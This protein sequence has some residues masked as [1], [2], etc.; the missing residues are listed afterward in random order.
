[1]PDEKE[2]F[3]IASSISDAAARQ[4]YLQQVCGDDLS[5]LNDVQSLLQAFETDESLLSGNAPIE[6]IEDDFKG[7]SASIVIQGRYKLLEQ[8]GEGGFGEVFM[9]EQLEPVRRRV[10]LKIIKAGM[11]SKQVLARFDAEQQALAMM[12]HPFVAKVIDAGQTDSGRPFF[13]MELVHGIPIID[14]CDEQQLTTHERLQLFA[15]V[16]TAVQHAHQKGIIHRDLKPTNILVYSDGDRSIP[17]IIDFGIA[18]ALHGRLTEKTLFTNFRQF[19]GT[20][21]YM[22]PEQARM[23]GVNV[24]TRSDIYSLGILLYELLTGTTPF[25]KEDLVDAGMDEVCRRI[26]DVPIPSPTQKLSSFQQDRMTQLARQRRTDPKLLRTAVSGE[27]DWI[28]MKA[29]EKEQRRRY[30]TVSALRSDVRNFLD[31]GHV[32]AVPPSWIY[33]ARCFTRR[34]RPLVVATTLVFAALVLGTAVST[35]FAL[36]ATKAEKLAL[37][38]EAQALS[39]AYDADMLLAWDYFDKKYFPS[40][41]KL[42]SRWV[43]ENAA[44]DFRGWEWRLL[45]ARFQDDAV[46]S[47]GDGQDPI[48]SMDDSPNGEWL[49][50]SGRDGALRVWDLET[51]RQVKHL[52]EDPNRTAHYNH[53]FFSP[54]GHD[55]IA[56]RPTGEIRF[57]STDTW[58]PLPRRKLEHGDRLRSMALSD[59][60]KWI[61]A[62]GYN[63]RL[64]VWDLETEKRYEK[65]L[66]GGGDTMAGAVAISQDSNLLAVACDTGLLRIVSLRNLEEIKELHVPENAISL[67]FAPDGTELACGLAF[68]NRNVHIFDTSTWELSQVLRGHQG[69]MRRVRFSSDGSQLASASADGTVRVWHKS[70]SW[71]EDRTYRGHFSEVWSVMFL[72]DNRLASGGKD[73]I[74]RVFEG[75]PQSAVPIELPQ[76]FDDA[77]LSPNGKTVVGIRDGTVELIT[78]TNF[79]TSQALDGLGEH[80]K[81]TLFAATNNR[82]AVSGKHE[83]SIIDLSNDGQPTVVGTGSIPAPV[84]P[85]QFSKNGD[86]LLTISDKGRIELWNKEVELLDNRVK[87]RHTAVIPLPG[88]NMAIVYDAAT[89]SSEVVDFSTGKLLVLSEEELSRLEAKHGRLFGK[90]FRRFV[91]TLL[92]LRSPEEV[93]ASRHIAISPDGN[94]IAR[95]YSK[96]LPITI[97]DAE[98]EREV[99]RL[100]GITGFNFREISFSGDGNSLLTSGFGN[101]YI[102][103]APAIHE[104]PN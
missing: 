50:T 43:P 1:M 98:T 35:W 75:E 54:S 103:R 83:L 49:A 67:D 11:D 34:H 82:F 10:A 9:A 44:R 46:A 104:L 5:L 18:K 93:F 72:G 92:P 59:D 52:A 29:L 81:H 102:W 89:R 28:V 96:S 2:I 12:D 45:T 69:Y 79:R 94:R 53:V 6:E 71:V 55:L 15:D 24:D 80:N 13:V 22:S 4:S 77:S 17:K 86:H 16:C 14:Y 57:W 39:V 100:T 99:A 25:L 42:L 20:P 41:R 32:I 58:S 95:G 37:E 23:G 56:G 76:Y 64:V 85:V 31:G 78:G 3:H 21:I 90:R 47:F 74:V 60:G 87:S 68:S 62:L 48:F 38:N 97:W 40:A 27:L 36:R 19:V 33:Q 61:A 51:H 65:Q 101:Y 8:I 66:P 70:D 73:G 7:Q 63:S 91:L 30:D 84:S 26:C 88:Y